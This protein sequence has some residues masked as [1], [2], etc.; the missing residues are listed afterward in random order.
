MH[1]VCI[2][3]K[4]SHVFKET[5]TLHQIPVKLI[6]AKTLKFLSNS[7]KIPLRGQFHINLSYFFI[8]KFTSRLINF[9]NFVAKDAQDAQD[10]H[11][12][13]VF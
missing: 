10:A 11:L 7:L 1:A 13:R 6:P 9:T 2:K 8:N 4:N 3:F 5:Y 12:L